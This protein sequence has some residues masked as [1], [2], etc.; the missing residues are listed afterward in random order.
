MKK[1]ILLAYL[2]GV[3]DGEG[4]VGLYI[5]GTHKKEMLPTIEVK[6]TTKH[7]I[8]LF[9]ETFGGAFWERPPPKKFPHHKT[10]W[11]WRL[12]GVRAVKVYKQLKPYLRLKYMD[13]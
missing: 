12:R 1:Q 4:T 8:E 3:V 7:I 5:C 11:R 6:M 13:V 2:A 10:Q 9:H